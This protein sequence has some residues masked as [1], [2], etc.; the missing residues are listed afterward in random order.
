[1]N[2][3]DSAASKGSAD[4]KGEGMS[5][6]TKA[7]LLYDL[8]KKSLAVSY[9]LWFFLG[10]PGFHRFY[11][12]RTGSAIVMLVLFVISSVLS[13]ILLAP[14]AWFVLGVWWF[15]D[16]FLIPGIVRQYNAGVIG[17]VDSEV[18]AS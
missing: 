17:Q 10:F 8:R 18:Q 5:S 1:M 3:R 12:A 15:V 9:L 16:L 14:I 4:S 7:M 13:V 6:H 2:S 11:M